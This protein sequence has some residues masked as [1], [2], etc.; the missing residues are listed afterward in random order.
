MF[1]LLVGDFAG[2]LDHALADGT[3]FPGNNFDDEAMPELFGFEV[4]FVG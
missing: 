3:V 4:F 1:S 2:G